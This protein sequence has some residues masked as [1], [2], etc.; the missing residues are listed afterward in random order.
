MDADPKSGHFEVRFESIGG[1]GAHAAA[2]VLATAAVL[3]LGLNGAA[4]SSYGSEKKGSPVRSF[5]RLCP[6]ELPIRTSAPVES[7]DVVVVFHAALLANPATF[8]GLKA[9]GTLIINAPPAP[10]PMSLSALPRTARVVRVDALAIA[11]EEKSRPNAVLLGTL[12]AAFPFLNALAVKE[13]LSEEFAGKHPEAVASNEQAFQRGAMEF[14]IV[15]NIGRAE[16]D[17]PPARSTPVWG[18]ETAPIGGFIPTAGNTIWN[19]LSASRTGWMPVLN[20]E[21]CIH[22]GLCDLVCPDLC[23]VWGDGEP[24]GGFERKLMGIDYHYCKGCLRCVESCPTGAL[25]K[26]AETPDLAEKLRVPL[27]P[28]IIE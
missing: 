16:G 5:V 14:E 7:P 19:D 8:S 13:A 20:K 12:C 6:A 27:F 17:L 10:L 4:F 3:R 26:Q 21:A 23:M 1:L 25:S 18:Y 9:K 28:E 24:D 15:E 22:C 11:V 2:Q